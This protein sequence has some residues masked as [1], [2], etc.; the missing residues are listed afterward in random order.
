MGQWLPVQ[1]GLNIPVG[2]SISV[3]SL[4]DYPVFRRFP[5]DSAAFPAVQKYSGLVDWCLTA[6]KGRRNSTQR[7]LDAE[8]GHP[9]IGRSWVGCSPP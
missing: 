2:L 8:K 5:P 4:H 7:R 6:G 1:E 9:L 3:Q